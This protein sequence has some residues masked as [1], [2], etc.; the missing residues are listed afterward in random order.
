MSYP[1]Q[2]SAVDRPLRRLSSG[3]EEH[4]DCV[5]DTAWTPT[6][7]DDV[8]GMTAECV[9]GVLVRATRVQDEYAHERAADGALLRPMRAE[10][11]HAGHG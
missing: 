11:G 1:R 7:T 6:L 9:Q 8:P 4:V 5:G 2:V 3:E 10:S